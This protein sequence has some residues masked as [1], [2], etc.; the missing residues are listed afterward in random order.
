MKYSATTPGSRQKMLDVLGIATVEELLASIPEG[1]RSSRGLDIPGPVAE[2]DLRLRLEAMKVRRPRAA[3]LGA[4]LY[5]HYVPAAVDSVAARSEWVTSYTPYQPELAQGTLTMY[6]E[7]QTYFARLTGQECANSGM[8]D[9]STALAEAVLMAR[10]LRPRSK[11]VVFVSRAVH[12]QYRAVL[13][14]Y[15]RFAELEIVEL[16]WDRVTGRTRVD[17]PVEELAD[18]VAVVFQTPNYFG[19]LEDLNDLPEGVFR[20][21]V[22]T[23]ALSMALLPPPQAE[24]TVGEAQSFGIPMQLGG[25]TAGFFATKNK[26][27]RKMP[28]RLVGRTVDAEG[29]EAFCITLATREQFIRR[30]KATSNICT[31][32]GLMCLRAA[33]YVSLLGG[34]GLTELAR[35]NAATARFFV[36][37]LAEIGIEPAFE[38]PWFN[39]CVLDLG[40]HPLL[41][42]RLIEKDI[43][44]GLPLGD[45]SPELAGRI[46]FCAT[47]MHASRAEELLQEIKS[48]V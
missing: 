38:G 30:E 47:E 42:D 32:S 29:S 6:Y 34:R 17:S 5:P 43:V 21:A 23:E 31:A 9:G 48:H 37:G 24:I 36:K 28:G 11:P 19:M 39:E 35:K 33:M 8:Y 2:A 41:W 45:H 27:I 1:D 20:I 40:K 14:T 15:A 25:P 16:D 22:C 44:L 46:L 12:P 26:W 4:G 13:R 3:F 10:R 18:A 7:F